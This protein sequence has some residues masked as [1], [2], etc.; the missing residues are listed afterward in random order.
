MDVNE[1]KTAIIDLQGV[2][3][4]FSVGK[5]T[6]KVLKGIDLSIASGEMTA[7]MG[8]SGC[9]KSTLLNIIGCLDVAQSGEYWLKGEKITGKSQKEMARIRNEVFGYVI[10]DFALIRE[11]SV[12]ENIQIPLDYSKKKID[13][14]RMDQLLKSLGLKKLQKTRVSLLSGGEQQRTAIARAL[15]NDPEI[16][17]A[18]EPTGALDSKTG[19][20]VM[21]ILRAIC[22]KGKTIVIVTHDEK[23]AQQC[24][25]ILYMR[26]GKMLK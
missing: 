17:L 5:R 21:N 18:D 2:C 25:R 15:V 24:D 1:E 16:L 8:A 14:A 23:I 20:E 26:D 6:A 9:G 12:L 13:K 22:D 4:S 19:Q 10:Q 3:K 7:I 11:D